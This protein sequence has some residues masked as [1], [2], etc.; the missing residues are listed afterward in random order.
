MNRKIIGTMAALGVVASL[1]FGGV[2]LAGGEDEVEGPDVEIIGTALDQASAA[3]LE[4]VGEGRVTGTEQGDEESYYEVEIT[5]D[6]GSQI[7][8]QL[9]EQFA[10]V[11]DE[12]EA[13]GD[14]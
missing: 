13:P 6:D 10:V 4:H 11:G 2:A 7:D 12:E 5:R 8:V 3:A 14:N 1:A 9:D